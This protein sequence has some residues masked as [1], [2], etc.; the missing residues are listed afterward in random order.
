MPTLFL[1]SLFQTFSYSNHCQQIKEENCF[2]LEGFIFN[3]PFSFSIN[4]I[5]KVA[6][7]LVI[8]NLGHISYITAIMAISITIVSFAEVKIVHFW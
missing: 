1:C 4:F 2:Y 3:Q 6:V 5:D 7:I 8:A